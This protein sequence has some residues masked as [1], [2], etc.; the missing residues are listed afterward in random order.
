VADKIKKKIRSDREN[1]KN[2]GWV[3]LSLT[4]SGFSFKSA[5]SLWRRQT[6]VRRV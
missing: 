4:D 3:G 6:R 1:H 2:Q 5:F